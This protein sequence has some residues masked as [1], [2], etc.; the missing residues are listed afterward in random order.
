MRCE[1]LQC[2]IAYCGESHRYEKKLT[3]RGSLTVP[4]AVICKSLMMLHSQC[5]KILHKE[6]DN[7]G[8]LC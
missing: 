3:G 2:K 5:E 8:F 6:A 1:S 7:N 4:L